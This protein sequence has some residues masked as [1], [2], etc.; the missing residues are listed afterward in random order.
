MANFCPLTA[1]IGW[2]V[3]GNPC[4]FQLVSLLGSVTA[5]HLVV[6]VSQTL[7]HWTQ[8]ETCIRQGDHHVGY[9][10]TFLVDVFF[11]KSFSLSLETCPH[12]LNLLS[13]TTVIT[14][15]VPS[16][17]KNYD[18]CYFNTTHPPY[19][20]HFSLLK[21]HLILTQTVHDNFTKS[22]SL[23]MADENTA[24]GRI[25]QTIMR[26]TLKQTKTRMW[27][28]AQCNGRPAEHRW[29]PLFNDAKFS[30]RPLLDA[31]Q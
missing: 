20:S 15:T 22:L 1:E 31:V 6:G 16:F 4:K 8:S 21:C 5:R 17:S 30:W 24:Q 18:I 13:C 11:T 2:P 26:L 12:H 7:W 27:A 10:P 23:I 28:N 14:S 19:H 29:R 25:R 3:W 9:W